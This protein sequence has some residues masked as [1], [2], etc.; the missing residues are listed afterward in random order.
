MGGLAIGLPILIHLLNKRR[1][2]IVDWAAMDFLFEAD[3]KNRR[4]VQVEN[5]ILLAL[6]CLAMLLVALLL[7][8]PFLPANVASVMQQTQ[9]IERVILVD[10]SLSQRVLVDAVPA[11]EKTK[12]NLKE[13]ISQFANS[14]E[15]ED[16]L[17]IY[18]TSNPTQPL[19]DNKPLTENVLAELSQA[20][21]QIECSDQVA[22]Y[23]VSLSELSRYLQGQ[24]EN[25]ARAVYVYTDMR[26]RDWMP[27]ADAEVDSAPNK[28]IQ[29]V[30]DSAINTFVVDTGSD[31]DANI[32][33][34]SVRPGE[35]V[36]ANKI[37]SFNVEVTNFGSQTVSDLRLLFQV[38]EDQPQYDT[39][40][41]IAPSQ[42]ETLT[43][44]HVFA[45][46]GSNAALNIDEL[47]Q[48]QNYRV[49]AE[50]DRQSLGDSDL[51]L[52]QLLEDSSRSYAVRSLEGVPILLVDGD[53][54][55]IPERSET[56]Y[57]RSLEL[58]GTGLKMDVA[59]VS[60]L[61]TVSLSDYAAIY[62][63]NVDEAS[64]D[65][66]QS[67]K[68]WVE[69]GGALVF[70][71]GNR[72]RAGTFN[73]AFYRD[74]AGIS[75]LKLNAMTGDPTMAQW[76]N[77]EI[78]PQIHPALKTV[79]DSDASSLGKVDIF[80]WWTSELDE[81]QIGKTVQVPLRLN[82]GANSVAMVERSLG[83]GRVVVFTIPAD[84]D[85][86]MWPG[87]PATF[88][89][90]MFDLIDYLV[91]NTA[92]ETTFTLGESISYPVDLSAYQ[93]RVSLR[94]PKKEKTETVAKPIDET[95]EQSLLYR[96]EFANLNRAGFY[97]AS[98]TRHTGAVEPVLFATN[99]DTQESELDRLG[100]E[101]RSAEFFG[102][103]VTLVSTSELGKQTVSG[104]NT[105]IWIWV[106]IILFGVLVTEQFL[107]WWWGRKR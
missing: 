23:T 9:Q 73:D 82:D 5:L 58:F 78:D 26:S 107:G 35:L 29:K 30:S 90:V 38:N 50:I 14:V 19:L 40:G 101:Q 55:A 33:I 22:D 7:A 15:T 4:R 52:D 97:T 28:L 87:V 46:G 77:F 8:R 81:E 96:A 17:T 53:P 49:R 64:P 41:S 39:I 92:S 34:T 11:I 42:T 45:K 2:K 12:E 18:L 16:W 60:E 1:F 105:E 20:I 71:P 24:R 63:C 76:V 56:H 86:S 70:M 32:A 91:G 59:T 62:L 74:G 54:S 99:Y 98:L 13:M 79:V 47:P 10:D 43:F 44:N 57:L 66:V 31:N 100:E 88:V 102:E 68:Q 37:I 72:V 84:G 6:R 104:G 67:L 85:W 80:S 83:D 94:D 51:A 103:K 3:K 48:F 27:M 89:P 95:S 21:D 61:E 36:V 93:N 75:P 106:L 65:R 69:D 25:V